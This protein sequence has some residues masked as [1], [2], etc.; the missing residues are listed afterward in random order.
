[1]G[2]SDVRA[3]DTELGKGTPLTSPFIEEGIYVGYRHYDTRGID[4]LFPFGYGLSYTEFVYSKLR[5]E[6]KRDSGVSI[7]LNVKNTGKSAGA[8]VV[9]LYVR[10]IE[11]SVDR[12]NK[13]LK[14]FAKIDLLPGQ[15]KQVAL[16][17]NRDAFAFFSPIQKMWIMEP[18]EFKLLVG[19]SS[20][21]IRLTKTITIE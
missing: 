15:T 11:T 18:G 17:L 21:D 10:D 14:A 5:I 6:T 7:T 13:E 12:P 16:F 19:S 2:D 3:N 8:E 20:R 1:M 4:P 9:Q